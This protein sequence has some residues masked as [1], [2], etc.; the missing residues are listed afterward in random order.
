MLTSSNFS[1][2]AVRS[3]ASLTRAVSSNSPAAAAAF[4]ARSP[5]AFSS[6]RLLASNS[7]VMQ[8][9]P[10]LQSLNSTSSKRAFGTTVRMVSLPCS[11]S[12]SYEKYDNKSR[13]RF[14]AQSP[15]RR[16]RSFYPAQQFDSMHRRAC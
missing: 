10:R 11:L 7:R 14:A 15:T 3:M 13:R 16:S 8:Q 5:A 1:R 4:A 2:A 9:F 6:R 12:M